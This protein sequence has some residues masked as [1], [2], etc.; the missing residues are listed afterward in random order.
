MTKAYRTRNCRH[1]VSKFQLACLCGAW[2][3]AASAASAQNP[4]VN[5]VMI[6]LDDL[7]ADAGGL[8]QTPHIDALAGQ[9]VSFTRAYA[10]APICGASR[11]AFLSG[12]LPVRGENSAAN[13]SPPNVTTLPDTL[14]AGNYRTRSLGKVYHNTGSTATSGAA[15][16]LNGWTDGVWRSSIDW[17][18]W[19]NQNPT[20]PSTGRGPAFESGQGVE[21]DFY[22]DGDTANQ[23][24]QDIGTLS[25]TGQPFFMA[26][27]FDRPHLPFNAPD[28]FWDIY[29]PND[30]VLPTN[31]SAPAGAPA[32][33]NG[34]TELTSYGGIPD[35]TANNTDGN[36]SDELRRNLIHGYLAST[37]Y[38]DAQVGRVLAALDDPNGDGD[39]SDSIRDNTIVALVGDHGYHLGEHGFWGKH[40]LLD[41]SL[42]V[43]L[44]VS[45]PQRA[46]TAGQTSDALVSLM[47]VYPT[48]ASLASLGTP[49]HVEGNSLVPLLAEPDREWAE[50]VYSHYNNGDSIRTDQ[51]RYIQYTNGQEALF[52]LV[53]DPGETQNVL[54]TAPAADVAYVRDILAA[55]FTNG[56]QPYLTGTFGDLN[57]DGNID[58]TDYADFLDGLNTSLAG[59]TNAQAYARGDLNGDFVTNLR[60]FILFRQAYDTANGD[61]ALLNAI[62][63]V[64]EPS[65]VIAL[66]GCCVVSLYWYLYY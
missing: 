58:L 22:A 4:P 12:V 52:D 57:G 46:D 14:V 45:D 13:A 55:H 41:T 42:R 23:A 38:A 24:I 3:V 51:Y 60:D 54:N 34:S 61:G 27:G 64:P 9:G 17:L 44:I 43:P 16:D 18:H 28:R 48:L 25:Q 15:D 29:D 30:I 37:S 40:N 21:D 33:I 66:L 26:V 19:Q 5:I 6:I 53:A 20:D 7:R 63:G 35:L 56:W 31:R 1:L 65:S 62:N 8:L 11:A 47:D 36:F 49:G 39:T 10:P 50:Y 59:L 2:L 32:S